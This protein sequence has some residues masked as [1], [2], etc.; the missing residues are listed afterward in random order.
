ML[1]DSLQIAL[2]GLIVLNV[3]ACTSVRPL[4]VCR[5]EHAE[6]RNLH[7]KADPY[8][9]YRFAGELRRILPQYI[10][11]SDKYVITIEVNEN[12]S[13][14]IYTQKEVAKEQIRMTSHIAV[15]DSFY[16]HLGS[17]QLD[18]YSTYEVCDEMPYSIITA[19][20]HARD[21]ATQELAQA[22][23]LAVKAIIMDAKKQ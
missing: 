14:A 9:E 12:T 13:S 3:T 11:D 18:T 7:I 21:T 2:C 8:V 1:R 19:K 23:V 15:Y 20:K 5:S 17:K 4:I 10:I 16:N 22:S 6:L